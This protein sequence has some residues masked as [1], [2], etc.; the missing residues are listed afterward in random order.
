VGV[1]TLVLAGTANA[2][3]SVVGDG[4]DYDIAGNT[5]RDWT[6]YGG[7]FDIDGDGQL[8]TD[9]WIF[10][11]EFNGASDAPV[12]GGLTYAAANIE[13]SLPTYIST[14]A[15]GADFVDIGRYWNMDR[16][17]IVDP[18]STATLDRSGCAKS[19]TGAAGNRRKI[20][21]FTVSGLPAL[22]T[23]RVGVFSGNQGSTLGEWQPTSLTLS[24]GD[25]TATVS[26]LPINPGGWANQESGQ[27]DLKDTVL[28][29]GWV[30]YDIDAD[31]T[32]AVSGTQ[33][34]ATTG[35]SVGA[36]VFDHVPEPATLALLGLGGLGLVLGRKRK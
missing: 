36:L 23:V 32:Y 30:F 20:M 14:H 27:P 33:R 1:L 2:G 13:D 4:S 7:A 35:C 26:A 11:G 16:Y 34:T 29:G 31:G 9:G 5:A 8:G 25:N 6:T 18:T 12:G 21:T 15:A 24:Q 17:G 19:T 10:Y 28:T 3:I 22:T